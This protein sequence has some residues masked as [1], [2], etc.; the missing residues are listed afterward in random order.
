MAEKT[1]MSTQVAYPSGI[2]KVRVIFQRII[3]KVKVIFCISL[4]KVRVTKSASH[5]TD[6]FILRW[7]SFYFR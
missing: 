2:N 7:K 3:N 1:R 6:A 4:L 5:L